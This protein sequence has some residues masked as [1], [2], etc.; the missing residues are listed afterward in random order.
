MDEKTIQIQKD[1]SEN[2]RY[3]LDSCSD[4]G[5]SRSVNQ[6]A[7]C[8]RI[9]KTP[10]HTIALAVVC[11][12]VGGLEEGEYASNSTIQAFNNWFDYRLSK[13]I[14]DKTRQDLLSVLSEEIKRI[15]LEKNGDIYLYGQR[16]GMSVGTTLTALLLVDM[17][18]FIAQIGDSRAYCMNEKLI[19]LTEDQSLVAREVREGKLTEEEAKSDKRRNIILQCLGVNENLFPAYQ[20]GRAQKGVTFLV[21]SDGFVHQLGKS[22][23]ECLMNTA[24]MNDINGIHN[25]L[26]KSIELVKERGEKDNITIVLVKAV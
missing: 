14:V 2:I 1:D 4:I 24:E 6:D 25:M 19:Q 23:L 12:G 22:E 20:I 10:S 5:T 9:M 7:C 21:C 3:I 13:L 18:Y 8:A 17:D 16:R 26:L 11:D 15:I